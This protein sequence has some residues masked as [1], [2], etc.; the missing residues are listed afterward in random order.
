MMAG[1][2]LLYRRLP[3]SINRVNQAV[4][5]AFTGEG[6]AGAPAEENFWNKTFC[7]KLPQNG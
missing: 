5:Y 2:L 7:Y 6:F 1:S 3:P 4:N